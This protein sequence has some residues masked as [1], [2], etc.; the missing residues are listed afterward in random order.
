MRCLLASCMKVPAARRVKDEGTEGNNNHRR[1]RCDRR[2]E[3]EPVP[4]ARHPME[5]FIPVGP[6]FSPSCFYQDVTARLF[7]FCLPR[8]S[9][10]PADSLPAAGRARC[11]RRRQKCRGESLLSLEFD[12]LHRSSFEASAS[13]WPNSPPSQP[14][15]RRSGKKKQKQISAML[16][17]APSLVRTLGD[18]TRFSLGF[19]ETFNEFIGC[20]V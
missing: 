4:V 3:P 13:S 18:V 5:S 19:L 6:P 7:R 1:G 20:D 17:H 14:T 10:E 15:S 8:E 12:T 11:E 9:L 2:S 16:S